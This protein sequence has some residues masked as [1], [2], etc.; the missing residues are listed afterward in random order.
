MADRKAFP[1]K[2]K[3]LKATFGSR[4][5]KDTLP[6]VENNLSKSDTLFKIQ[7]IDNH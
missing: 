7:E 4:L 5:G 2:R 6:D 3:H 1:R